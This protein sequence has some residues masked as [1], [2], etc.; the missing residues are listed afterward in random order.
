MQQLSIGH[1]SSQQLLPTRRRIWHFTALWQHCWHF[2]MVGPD[3]AK[4]QGFKSRNN[5]IA[6][7]ALLEKWSDTTHVPATILEDDDD[8]PRIYHT[9]MHSVLVVYQYISMI[10]LFMPHRLSPCCLVALLS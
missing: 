9:Y 8:S 10:D 7:I 5:V 3:P 1:D 6:L 4:G 2:I